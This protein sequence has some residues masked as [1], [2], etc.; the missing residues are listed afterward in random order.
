FSFNSEGA[1]RFGELTG[2]NLPDPV[3]GV[4][5]D[6]AIVLDGSLMSAATIRS[7][8]S[9]NGRITGSFSDEDVNFIV[10]VL[11]A[12]ALPAA[13]QKEPV[14]EERISAELGQ[15][16]IQNSFVS[17]IV[18]T[19]AVLLFMLFYYRFAGIVANAAVIF[20]LVL[21]LALMIVFK[22]AFTLA[23]LAG[24]VLSV[25][26]AVD[27]NVLIYERMREE[28][29]RGAA[30]RMVIRNGF[31]RAMATIIDTHSTTIITGVILYAI[32]TE[33]L[34][35]FAVTLVMGLA[36]NL[37]TAVFCARVVFD[38]AERQ[39]WLTELKML[40]LFGETK[41]DF[42]SIMKPAIAISIL[43]SAAGIVAVCLRGS[44]ILDVDF[45]GGSEV[46]IAFNP[47]K[48]E[49]VSQVRKALDQPDVAKILPDATVS[50][51]TSA[52]GQ[53]NTQFVVRTSNDKIREVEDELSKVFGDRLRHYKAA[54]FTNPHRIEAK[55]PA[56]V[57]P[58]AGPPKSSSGATTG[59]QTH[60]VTPP[61]IV[62]PNAETP[63]PDTGKT[64]SSKADATK[65]DSSKADGSKNATG[66]NDTG[67]T[68]GGKS[69]AKPAPAPEP[70]KGSFLPRLDR[71]L[72]AL[73]APSVL[74]ADDNGAKNPAGAKSDSAP[75]ADTGD[76][77]PALDTKSKGTDKAVDAKPSEST[78]A[79]QAESTPPDTKPVDEKAAPKSGDTKASAPEA[80]SAE[81]SRFAARASAAPGRD[82]FIGG[83]EVT[84]EFDDPIKYDSLKELLDQ[85]IDP[86]KVQYDLSNPEY[87]A[88]SKEHA[89]NTWTLRL[90]IPPEQATAILNSFATKL[91][92]TPVFLGDSTIGS[93]VAADTERTAIV[94]LIASIAMIVVYIWIRFQNVIYGIGAV[95]ALVHDVLVTVAG[96]ALSYY[97]AGFLG[98]LLVDPFKISLN[99]VAALLTIVGYSISDTIVIF[100]RIREVRGKSPDLTEEM[101]NKS[102]NQTLSRTVLTVFTVLLVTIILYIAGGQA[103]HAFAFTM[104]IGL[105]SGTYSS[106][107]IAA[108]CLLWLKQPG[109]QRR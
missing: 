14:S 42:V 53:E 16:T 58:E 55:A 75:K 71:I 49:D 76:T 46:Q 9:D 26:M 97:V 47:D 25:G 89:F 72:L 63:K 77:K 83:T 11:N 80:T 98:F 29:E 81:K 91:A 59:T 8:I 101:I 51:V 62:P 50:A 37:F 92:S 74:L 85:T 40:K 107:Y 79:K 108:P 3:S 39:R 65:A 100:D 15:D 33:Q 19:A 4:G 78:A 6:L 10:D 41:I 68:E 70:N 103:I 43:I 54:R 34:R 44:T 86:K 60:N 102:V 36:V 73:A 104:L 35:G 57:V 106:V 66:K 64:D 38:V 67:K 28:K 61:P 13:L 24:L 12:G 90:S 22:A 27:S 18:S 20:N 21:V 52:K 1:S 17:M 56:A 23:G 7:R 87:A 48:A 82:S 96:V 105:I 93:R 94:A 31:G 95:V 45:T 5:R 2:Q 99:V 69:D 109:G 88:G 30:L 32:G 84:L